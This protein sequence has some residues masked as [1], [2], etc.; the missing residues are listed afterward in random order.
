MAF[1]AEDWT[2]K[3]R[4]AQGLGPKIEDEAVVSRIKIL[5]RLDISERRKPQDGKLQFR[6]SEEKVEFRVATIPTATR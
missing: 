4:A 1:S 2:T 5:A 6:R 3:S